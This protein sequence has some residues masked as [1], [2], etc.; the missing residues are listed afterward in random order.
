MCSIQSQTVENKNP[1][2]ISQ[3]FQYAVYPLVN[4]SKSFC[5]NYRYPTLHTQKG[6]KRNTYPHNHALTMRPECKYVQIRYYSFSTSQPPDSNPLL[7][8][9]HSSSESQDKDQASDDERCL[10]NRAH[11]G[12]TGRVL[13]ARRGS[14]GSSGSRARVA[15]ASA[16]RVLRSVALQTGASAGASSHELSHG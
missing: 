11:L 6:T 9:Q 7:S 3:Y 2:M 15:S 16:T 14:S 12:D 8:Q 4:P 1:L 5:P 10:L 13:A